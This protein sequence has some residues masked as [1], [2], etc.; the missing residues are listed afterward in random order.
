MAPEGGSRPGWPPRGG[1][2]ARAG[3]AQAP[4]TPLRYL[5]QGCIPGGKA[6][7]FVVGRGKGIRG[8]VSFVSIYEKNLYGMVLF[9]NK[10]TNLIGKEYHK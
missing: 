6:K 3:G 10:E 7:D 2:W 5:I 1:S 8:N 9:E 4:Q